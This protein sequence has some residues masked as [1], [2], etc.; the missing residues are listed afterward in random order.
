M[1][2]YLVDVVRFWYIFAYFL[3]LCVVI[4]CYI[5]AYFKYCFLELSS[6]NAVKL[7]RDLGENQRREFV[8]LYYDGVPS[9][10]FFLDLT[11][12]NESR[13]FMSVYQHGALVVH[14]GM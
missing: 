13:E 5:S 11:L 8:S 3:F 6:N 4:F 9:H 12:E 14:R 2:L 1:L 7:W 10:D